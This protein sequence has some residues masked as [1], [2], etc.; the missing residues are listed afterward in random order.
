MS[1]LLDILKEKRPNL[2]SSSLNTYESILKSIH[3][4]VFPGEKVIKIENFLDHKPFLMHLS[5]TPP[6]ISKTK[7]SALYVLTEKPEY[8]EEM[9]KNIDR[10]EQS[11]KNQTKTPEQEL[12]WAT[13]K[14]IDELL[15]Q[16]KREADA[17]YKKTKL[18]Q[19]NYQTIQNYILLVLYSGKYI[20]PRRSRDYTSFKVN[21]VNKKTDNFYDGKHFV[22]ND[23]KTAKFYD[24][25]KIP[26]PPKLKTI[27]KKWIT[28]IESV[29]DYL[30]FDTQFK[31]LNSVKLNQRLNKIFGRKVSVNALR[32]S[33]LS[34][35]FGHT[36]DIKKDLEDTMRDMGSSTAQE[37]I[38]IKQ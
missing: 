26:V 13:P 1:A 31:P 22:F 24:T 25:Q 9:L 20:I 8:R 15:T 37:T 10:Y 14:E 5:K 34:A 28:K 30:L 4:K 27:I 19:G 23:Y 32:K 3:R 11:I 21:S 35:K 16:H 2:T 36:I 17:L 7:L 33:F 6:N 29:S 38:Y 12:H 18:T